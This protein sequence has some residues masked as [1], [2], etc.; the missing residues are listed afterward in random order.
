V[1]ESSQPTFRASL[2]ASLKRLK[3]DMA[4]AF[5]PET[6]KFFIFDS[7]EDSSDFAESRQ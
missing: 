7:K 1:S 6:F 5:S 4:H 2:T 3:A